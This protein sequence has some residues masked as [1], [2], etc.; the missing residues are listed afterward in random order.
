[1]ARYGTVTYGSARYGLAQGTPLSV[2]SGTNK[3]WNAN[4]A[5]GAIVRHGI[6]A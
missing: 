1:M 2:T 3:T 4:L 5:K 6:G